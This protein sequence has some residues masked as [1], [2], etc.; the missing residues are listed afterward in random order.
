V[1]KFPTLERWMRSKVSRALVPQTLHRYRRTVEFVLRTLTREGRPTHP[2][3][4]KLSDACRIKEIVHGH[5]WDL[6][7]LSDFARSFG[8][9]VIREAGIPRS[10]TPTHVR[11]LSRPQVEAIVRLTRDDPLLAFVAFLGLGQ[12]LRRVEWLRMQVGDVDLGG[13]RLLVR[14]KGRS[15]PKVQWVPM[16]PSFPE[17][18]RGYSE[19][20]THLVATAQRIQPNALIPPEL[21]VHR[22]PY[23]LSRYS[24]GGL[25]LLVR[26][27][28]KRVIR[29]GVPL[30]L[31]SHMLRRSGATLL[32]ACGTARI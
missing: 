4:W 32:G 13:R 10:P 23:G 26:R 31:S 24:V 7:V 14:G 6:T 11:W 28:E 16:H 3:R 2:A 1:P 9:D 22:S 12:A 5:H 17:V 8:N 18:Y 30:R 19:Y 27:I 25:D 15:H 21:L 29:A 20:R